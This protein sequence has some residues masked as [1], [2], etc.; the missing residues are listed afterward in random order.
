MNVLTLLGSYAH[1]GAAI[2]GLSSQVCHG[3]RYQENVCGVK[4]E[5]NKRQ[6]DLSCWWGR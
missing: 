4:F 2:N 5:G 6:T 3:K 1:S